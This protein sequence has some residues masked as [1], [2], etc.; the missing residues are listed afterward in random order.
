MI[1]NNRISNPEIKIKNKY[2]SVNNSPEKDPDINYEL[3]NT[4]RDYDKNKYKKAFLKG[5]DHTVQNEVLKKV[6]KV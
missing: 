6:I 1:F 5:N 3:Y 2:R 4:E